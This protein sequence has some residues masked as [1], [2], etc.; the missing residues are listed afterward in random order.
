MEWILF[1]SLVLA[2]LAL[3]LGV[4]HRRP[5]VIPLREALG[6]SLLWIGLAA[7][8]GLFLYSWMGRSSALEFATGY[9]VE[10]SLSADNLF[11]FLVIFRYFQVPEVYRHKVLFWGILGALLLRGA[12]IVVGIGLIRRLHWVIYAFGGFVVYTGA[13]LAVAGKTDVQPERNVTL[14]LFHRF[15]PVTSGYAADRFFVRRGKLYATPLFLVLLAV[16]ASDVLFATDSVLA[17]LAIT[18]QPFIAYTS[19]VFALL[20]LRSMYF[21]VAG[22]LELFDYLH[23]GLALI[24]VFIGVKMLL[25]EYY[26]VPAGIALGTVAAI[27]ALSILLSWLRPRRSKV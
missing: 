8:F 26:V 9:V 24:L 16:E 5:R 15:F 23:Y 18:R 17:V 10:G 19:N 2:L 4:L 20:G 22:M 14:R 21:V 6:A 7:A 27:L 12:F 13:K 11:V 1:N 3:D 25:S